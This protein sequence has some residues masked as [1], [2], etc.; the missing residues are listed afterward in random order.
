MTTRYRLALAL[1]G[2]VSLP[3]LALEQPMP[4]V[5]VTSLNCQLPGSPP[6]AKS[7]QDPFDLYSWLMFIALNWPVT[8]GQRGTPDCNKKPGDAGYTVWQSYK[9]VSEIFP[10][11]GSNPGPWNTP[12]TARNLGMINISALKNTSVLQA[13]DQ[14]VGGWLIDQRGNPT[15]YDIS[16]NE[17]SYNYIVA[18]DFY[19]ANVVSKAS[20]ISFP[21]GVIEVKSSWRILTP[22]DNASR[23]LTVHSQVDLFDDQGKPTGAVEDA[24][25]G[26]VGLHIITKVQGYPQWIW[27]TF[28]QVD[29]VPPKKESGGQWIDNPTSGINYS[30]FNPHAEPA[31]LNQSP[32]DWQTQDNKMVCV[33]KAG[34][35]FQT[36]N[37]LNRVTPIAL[38][39]EL[40]N[41][42]FQLNP[43]LQQSALKY[44]QLVTTQ[45]PFNPNNPGNPLGQPTPALSANVTMESYIQANSSC[46]ACHSMATPVGSP[47]KA[48]FSYMFKFAQPAAQGA[49][50]EK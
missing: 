47:Y 19:N 48:D 45:R 14:A 32:C 22:A 34:T 23:Y 20:N 15:Y 30:Y 8:D 7:G 6:A 49:K 24:Y 28:E 1:L 31:S 17:V 43:G 2:S 16:A 26:L 44:Y 10:A 38:S 46:M 29:N 50:D 36:P 39:T 11:D 33:P 37:P 35:T 25:L 9:N 3:A 40:I 13:V 21:N 4:D 18:N 12:L 41:K 42:G 27:S 5:S